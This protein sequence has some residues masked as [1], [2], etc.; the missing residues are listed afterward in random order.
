MWIFLL[1]AAALLAAAESP[2]VIHAHQDFE[3]LRQHVAIPGRATEAYIHIGPES[4]RL[5]VTD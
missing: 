3:Q 2:A 4:A 5:H 1:L